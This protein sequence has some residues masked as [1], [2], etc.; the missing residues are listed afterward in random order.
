MN[1]LL[2]DTGRIHLIDVGEIRRP[3]DST[4][5]GGENCVLKHSRHNGRLLRTAGNTDENK[6]V[7]CVRSTIYPCLCEYHGRS[8]RW[9]V[10]LHMG[11]RTR[12]N[13]VYQAKPG[14]GKR[15]RV[16]RRSKRDQQDRND[17]LP[18]YLLRICAFAN[19]KGREHN[20]ETAPMSI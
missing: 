14:M 4:D 7:T 18:S 19:R 8:G 2:I 13:R 16:K 20:N 9:A 15:C 6:P 3:E 11:Q 10:C 5:D 1:C 17:K 12:S